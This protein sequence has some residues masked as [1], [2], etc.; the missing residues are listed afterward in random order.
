MDV[1]ISIVISIIGAISVI[2][3]FA[4]Y[5]RLSPFQ[6]SYTKDIYTIQMIKLPIGRLIYLR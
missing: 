4:P 5:T 3:I 1:I 6:W 2:L